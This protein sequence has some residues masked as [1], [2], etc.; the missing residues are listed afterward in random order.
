MSG[1]LIGGQFTSGLRPVIASA[2]CSE[3]SD[4]MR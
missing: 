1:G 3:M 2:L 4:E